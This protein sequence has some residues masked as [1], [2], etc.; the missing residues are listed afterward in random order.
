MTVISETAGLLGF[1]VGKQITMPLII[2]QKKP[3]ARILGATSCR[4]CFAYPLSYSSLCRQVDA[5]KGRGGRRGYN[6][7]GSKMK[8]KRKLRSIVASEP[9]ET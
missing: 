3:F 8:F 4:T 5:Y 7:K 2:V 1:K 6:G 9:D